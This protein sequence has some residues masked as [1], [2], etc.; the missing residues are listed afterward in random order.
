[1]KIELDLEAMKEIGVDSNVRAVLSGDLLILVVDVS[2]DLGPS[3]TGKMHAVGN[4]SGF[5][6]FPGGLKGNVYVGR[7][8]ID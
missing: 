4:T 7:K 8:V 6:L 3:S 5:Q 2:R 1:M